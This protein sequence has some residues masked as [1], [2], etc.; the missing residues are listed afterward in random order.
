MTTAP[1]PTAA[2]PRITRFQQWLAAQHDLAL[3]DYDALWQWSVDQ[4]AAFWAALWQ[5]FEV[6]SPTPWTSVLAEPRMPG[7]RWFEGSQVNLARQVLRH[8]ETAHA[9]GQPALL[10]RN[11]VLMAH[12]RT[13]QLGWPELRRQVASLALGLREL[14]VER[15]DR[16][17]AQLPNAPMTVIAFLACASIGA[18]WSLCSPD[19]GPVAVLDRFRQIAPKVLICADA[20]LHAGKLHDLRAQTGQIAAGLPS[21]RHVLFWPY[22]DASN[23]AGPLTDGGEHGQVVL[24]NRQPPQV[25]DLRTLLA[26]DPP[27]FEPA[28]LPFDHPLWIVYSSGTT[29]LPKPIVHGHG[30]ILLEGLKLAGLHL[31]LA[32]SA[33]R[34]GERFFWHT[35][36]GWVMWNCQLYA[37][38][39]G[40]T[41]CL[42]DGHPAG[43]RE[44]ADWSQLWRF[45]AATGTSFF[46]AGSAFFHQCRLAGLDLAELRE[47]GPAGQPAPLAALRA[48]GATGSALDD[49]G[50]DWIWQQL[51]R[52]PD[53]A[54]IWLCGISGGTDI[55]SAFLGGHPGLPQ[56]RGEMQVRCLGAAVEAW[57]EPDATGHGRPLPP[58]EV[59]ELVCTRPMPSMPL[60]FWG[61][62]DGCRYR[63]SYFEFYA[64]RPGLG[65]VWR[66][67]DWLRLQPHPEDGPHG[68]TGAVILGR[69]DAT[70]NRHGVRLGTAELYRVIESLPEV[71]DSLAVDLAPADAPH[72]LLLF[73]VL[74]DGQT[75]DAALDARLR[76]RIRTLLSARHLPDRIVQA[77]ALPYTLSGKKMELPVKR[78]LLGADPASVLRRDAMANGAAIDWLLGWART[79]HE[80]RTGA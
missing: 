40:T 25:H 15:G 44:A 43:S 75:L 70:L 24:V 30:G 63:E 18:V 31:D 8:V 62:A 26:D 7:A 69:S 39:N 45:A 50:H 11:E 27:D 60:Q 59:G 77:P 71:R 64:E 20:S 80:P 57:S 10:F 33:E 78:L 68:A 5:Y 65:P 72:E 54:P 42:Y 58:G 21:L 79:R 56:R 67:G 74:Q 41:L 37:L 47:P 34:P 38:L 53:G 29:G 61:D 28:W 48:V 4:P 14:G 3:A 73:V 9:A 17:V 6:E 16:V 23:C 51:P 66:H 12:E 46:G 49:A 52:Q 32:P 1:A 13:L 19:M 55:A 22:I 36:S 2:A 76:E 35:G